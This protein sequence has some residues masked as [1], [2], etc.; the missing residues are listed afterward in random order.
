MQPGDLR[1]GRGGAAPRTPQPQHKAADRGERVAIDG[2]KVE[3]AACP[4]AGAIDIEPRR[5]ADDRGADGRRPPHIVAGRNGLVLPLH[6]A[7]GVLTLGAISGLAA[8]GGDH[9]E[10]SGADA[11]RAIMARKRA[12]HERGQR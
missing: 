3:A 10:A 6:H 7:R 4:A 12:K 2:P 11:H 9:V 1:H 5:P 8:H